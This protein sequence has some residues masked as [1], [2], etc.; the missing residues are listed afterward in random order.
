MAKIEGHDGLYYVEINRFDQ[1]IYFLT[2]LVWLRESNAL[3]SPA[4]AVIIWDGVI[5]I[6]I[7]VQPLRSFGFEA[8]C[9]RISSS[10]AKKASC[11]ASPRVFGFLFPINGEHDNG[12]VLRCEWKTYKGTDN[13]YIERDRPYLTNRMNMNVFFSKTREALSPQKSRR[14]SRRARRTQRKDYGLRALQ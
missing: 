1:I 9:E 2:T 6:A 5:M 11:I 13:L 10:T 14:F 8:N 4:F 3:E 7:A 12:R